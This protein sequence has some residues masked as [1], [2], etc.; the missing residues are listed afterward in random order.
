MA[1]AVDED[2]DAFLSHRSRGQADGR[3]ACREARIRA[4]ERSRNHRRAAAARRHRTAA[5]V[6]ADR[7]D[8]HPDHPAVSDHAPRSRPRRSRGEDRGRTRAYEEKYSARSE[9][10]DERHRAFDD[11]EAELH[12]LLGQIGMRDLAHSHAINVGLGHGL[13]RPFFHRDVQE[14]VGV[15]LS[16]KALGEAARVLPGLVPLCAAAERMAGVASNAFDLHLS[17]GPCSRVS[18]TSARPCSRPGES[19]AAAGERWFRCLRLFR[20]GAPAHRAAATGRTGSRSGSAVRDRR[21][22][23]A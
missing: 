10:E 20:P 6:P 7:R 23:R 15:D 19:C 4:Q 17:R 16:G 1:G 11:W 13:E 9:K 5:G 3:T 12:A 14:L 18:S 22:G 21:A 2:S 8:D